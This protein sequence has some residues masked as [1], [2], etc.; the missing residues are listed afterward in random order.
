LSKESLFFG[1]EDI[2]QHQFL[3]CLIHHFSHEMVEES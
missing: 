3:G 2:Q 1:S